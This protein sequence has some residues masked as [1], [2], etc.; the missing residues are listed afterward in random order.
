M[1]RVCR[2]IGRDT[3][4]RKEKRMSLKSNLSKVFSGSLGTY[5]ENIDI[6]DEGLLRKI[7]NLRKEEI[8]RYGANVEQ[9]N[10]VLNILELLGEKRERMDSLQKQIES[11]ESKM[12]EVNLKPSHMEGRPL[13]DTEK[14]LLTNY[15]KQIE[16][17]RQQLAELR[18]YYQRALVRYDNALKE[19]LTKY[20]ASKEST[21]NSF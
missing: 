16:I 3:T 7:G 13:S 17:K 15:G 14:A 1:Q 20:D 19:I 8:E 2:L 18:D 5:L 4:R 10:I 12:R 9:Q 11:I 21:I 6:G